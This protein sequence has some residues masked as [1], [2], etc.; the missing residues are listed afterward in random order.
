MRFESFVAT[1]IH[2]Y[3]FANIYSLFVHLIDWMAT[4]LSMPRLHESIGQPCMYN[5]TPGLRWSH[6]SHREHGTAQQTTCKQPHAA[7]PC[8]IIPHGTRVRCSSP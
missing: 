4:C 7:S 3:Y 5:T 2:F 6:D 1:Y 8:P